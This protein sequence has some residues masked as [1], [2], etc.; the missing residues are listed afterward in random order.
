[1]NP[2]V[3]AVATTPDQIEIKFVKGLPTFLF[4]QTLTTI[5][6]SANDNAVLATSYDR[7]ALDASDPLALAALGA[8][9]AQA[10]QS[11]QACQAQLQAAQDQLAQL[12]AKP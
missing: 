2:V 8:L 3:P 1:M 11:L 4:L 12:Q 7:S 5:T 6:D 10:L 9:P